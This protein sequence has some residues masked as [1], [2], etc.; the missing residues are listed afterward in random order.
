MQIGDAPANHSIFSAGL[1]GIQKNLENF[2][3]SVEKIAKVTV[4]RDMPKDLLEMKASQRGV[5]ASMVTVRAADEM[6]GTLLD[7]MA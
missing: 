2:N 1:S 3:S 7:V 6:L 5:Q 4:L